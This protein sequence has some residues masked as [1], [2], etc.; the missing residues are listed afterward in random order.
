MGNTVDNTTAATCTPIIMNKDI[1]VPLYSVSGL[2]L[3]ETDIAYP[4]GLIAKSVFTDNYTLS[5]VDAV[6]PSIKTP[7]DFNS[8]NIAWK[9]DREKFKNQEG[10]WQD[11]Q[12]YDVTDRKSLFSQNFSLFCV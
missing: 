8:D 1:S 6:D 12:W 3:N 2:L 7:I 4:C 5:Y 11:K 10:I 9:S